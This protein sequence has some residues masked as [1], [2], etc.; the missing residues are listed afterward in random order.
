MTAAGLPVRGTQTGDTDLIGRLREWII[1]RA[2]V[3]PDAWAPIEADLRREFGGRDHYVHRRSKADRLQRLAALP[4]D[5]PVKDR[6]A[7]TDLAPSRMYEL[8]T[9]LDR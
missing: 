8:W 2:G 3:S 6:C 5:A 1:E 7:A 9:L 4:P